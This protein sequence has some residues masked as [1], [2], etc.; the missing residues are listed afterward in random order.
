MVI[1]LWLNPVKYS[2][3]QYFEGQRDT[4]TDYV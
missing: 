4:V 3:M 1:I 2:N